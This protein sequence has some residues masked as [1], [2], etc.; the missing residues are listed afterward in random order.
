MN[1]IATAQL[2]LALAELVDTGQ[3]PACLAEPNLWVSERPADRIVA[4]RRC[5]G[6][7]VITECAAAAK[8]IHAGFGVWAARDRTKQP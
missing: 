1:T 6:C 3:R 4:A 2:H 5:T 7:R 8:E